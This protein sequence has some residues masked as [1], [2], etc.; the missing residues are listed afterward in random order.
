MFAFVHF[1]HIFFFIFRFRR[2]NITKSNATTTHRQ[3]LTSQY[4]YCN[5]LNEKQNNN[6]NVIN[7]H[8]E[9]DGNQSELGNVSRN[10][11]SATAGTHRHSR[12]RIVLNNN[13]NDTNSISHIVLNAIIGILFYVSCYYL[14]SVVTYV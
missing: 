11:V 2:Q 8:N 9:D 7:S 10:A 12:H 5:K 13:F 6:N 14:Y 1:V 4:F 3:D